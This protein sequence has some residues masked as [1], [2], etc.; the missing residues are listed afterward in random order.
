MLDRNW[1]IRRNLSDE[2]IEQET[3]CWYDLLSE[4]CQKTKEDVD[5]LVTTLSD[6]ELHRSF[7]CG[8]GT[9]EG[10]PFTAW[11]SMFVYFPVVYDGS[12]WVGYAPRNPCEKATAHWGR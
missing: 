9:I 2:E 7:F 10:A 5:S 6:E 1:K 4:A 3:T 8:Y 12:E 11:G